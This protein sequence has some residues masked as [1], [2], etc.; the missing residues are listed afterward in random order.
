[1]EAQSPPLPPEERRA[2]L[3]GSLLGRRLLEVA[4]LSPIEFVQREFE[5]DAIRAGLLFF[6]GLRE[7][8][9]RL[10]GF[11]HSIPALLAGKHKAQMCVG[12]S[13]LISAN[14]WIGSISRS[15]CQDRAS[16]R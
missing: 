12:G 10:P 5:H 2:K 7:I 3:A 14:C 13:V 6:N 8:D 9:L 1:V 16:R 4:Q 15:K 11:G